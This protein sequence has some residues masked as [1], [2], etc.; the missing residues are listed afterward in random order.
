M[1]GLL[2]L[3]IA[4][5]PSDNN[6]SQ[7]LFDATLACRNLHGTVTARIRHR[8]GRTVVGITRKVH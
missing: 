6:L 8:D 7:Q 2:I 3:R 4:T 5:T 1:R